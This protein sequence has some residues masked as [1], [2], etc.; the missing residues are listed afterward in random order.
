MAPL[1]TASTTT[2][3]APCDPAF[4]V[5]GRQLEDRGAS[6][7]QD[8]VSAQIVQCCVLVH[9]D[10]I[11]PKILKNSKSESSNRVPNFPDDER[12]RFTIGPRF[13]SR[14]LGDR[15]WPTRISPRSARRHRTVRARPECAAL[16]S[17]PHRN[18]NAAAETQAE[19]MCSLRFSGLKRGGPLHILRVASFRGDR[20]VRRCRP[21][22]ILPTTKSS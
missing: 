22:I 9:A 21:T 2:A 8:L 16:G 19:S 11:N 20:C 12:G 6:A 15:L 3:S 1:R 17:C 4:G 13:V 7:R 10:R 18:C 5:R 14:R